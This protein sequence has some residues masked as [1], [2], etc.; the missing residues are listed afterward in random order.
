MLVFAIII[1]PAVFLCRCHAP[2]QLALRA[3]FL[4]PQLQNILHL[5]L[6]LNTIQTKPT[7]LL[8]NDI[9]QVQIGH[10]FEGYPELLLLNLP[11]RFLQHFLLGIT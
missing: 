2:L 10:S 9:L 6:D 4:L 1:P 5:C 8:N 3:D 11:G 7:H